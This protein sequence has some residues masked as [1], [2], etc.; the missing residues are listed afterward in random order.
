MSPKS[1]EQFEEIRQKST[2]K[3]KEVALEL[4]SQRGFHNTTISQIAK[5]AGISKGLMYNYFGSKEA[6]L[7]AIVS[8]AVSEFEHLTSTLLSQEGSASEK[9]AM[10][11]DMAIEV[12][13]SD[14]KHWRLLTSLSLQTDVIE[15]LKEV[16]RLKSEQA[17]ALTEALFKQM[18]FEDPRKEAFIYGALMDGMM[19]HYVSMSTLEMEY[20]VEQMR[21]FIYER[22]INHQAN[23]QQHE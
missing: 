22:Y 12:V 13:S 16:L 1:A 15:Q 9:L 14:L 20:P 4:F 19:L 18:G 10:M 8:E 21:S 3:I 2:E 23:N 7:H 17:I 5:E 6:L 11:T